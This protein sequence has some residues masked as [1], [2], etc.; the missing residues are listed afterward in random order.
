MARP[1]H[2][3]VVKNDQTNNEQTAES[4]RLSEGN[5][6][7]SFADEF[8]TAVRSLDSQH[9]LTFENAPHLAVPLEKADSPAMQELTHRHMKE[10]G[11]WASATAKALAADYFNAQC[12]RAKPGS[13][14]LR[15]DFIGNTIYLDT[16]W[17]G[18]EVIV[19]DGK[20]V[21]L[22][23]TCEAIFMRSG[24]SGSLPHLGEPGVSLKR[25]LDFVRIPE[26]AL[27][28]LVACL[29]NSLIT[30]MPQPLMLIQG[31]A[32]TGKTTSLRMLMDLID[33]STSMAGGSLSDDERAVRA[34]SKVRRVLV[35]DNVSYV[36]GDASDLLAKITTGS[37]LITRALYQNSTPDVLQLKRPVILNGII[38]GFSR[39]DLASR[40]VAFNLQPVAAGERVPE[41]ELKRAWSEVLPSLFRSLLDMASVV[42]R[43]LEGTPMPE[44]NFRNPDLVK[45][46]YII[47]KQLGINGMQHL[48]TSVAELSASVLGASA[49]GQAF[50]KLVACWNSGGC[51]H[52][53]NQLDECF[54]TALTVEKLRGVLLDHLD[55]SEHKSIPAL[56]KGFGEALKRI[57]SDLASVL[58]L[59][60]SKKRTNASMT[61]ILEVD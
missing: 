47:G 33:P 61:Y 9:F 53:G 38:D 46:T 39:S 32:G 41:P 27:P 44:T 58:G 60:V 45:M 17:D 22:E 3:S 21:R 8:S 1:S 10:S 2:L 30:E 6:L 7:I 31:P 19:I 37:E 13:V 18:N 29:V 24:V 59:V 51:G 54:D 12:L 50:T 25:L 23:D 11:K 48:E 43:E 26:S 36:K 20:G 35:F 42:L 15:C 14:A 40:T 55:E 57:E 52:H 28:A 34:L 5:R 56:H 16:C 49:M 4:G